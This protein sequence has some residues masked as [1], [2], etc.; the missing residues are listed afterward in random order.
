MNST[1]TLLTLMTRLI[2]ESGDLALLNTQ[3]VSLSKKHGQL[4][5]AV[6]RM[7][8]EAMKWLDP[9]R[10][11]KGD[12]PWLELLETLRGITEGK[13]SADRIDFLLG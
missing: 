2:Y 7:V 10:S 3:L 4:K 6:V 5:E 1:A 9:I 11:S 8:D 13:V 12:G